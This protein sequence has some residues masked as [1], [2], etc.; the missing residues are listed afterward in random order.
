MTQEQ[1]KIQNRLRQLHNEKSKA[2]RAQRDLQVWSSGEV[3]SK[4]V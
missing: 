2:E 1:V 3:D 4:G